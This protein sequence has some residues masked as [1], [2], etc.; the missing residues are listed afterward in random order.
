MGELNQ[1]QEVFTLVFRL[2]NLPGLLMP[3]TQQDSFSIWGPPLAH[4]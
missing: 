4:S 3:Q 2:A 1:V